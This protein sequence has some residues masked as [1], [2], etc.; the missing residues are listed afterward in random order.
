MRIQ[1]LLENGRIEVPS[2][3]VEHMQFLLEF[4]SAALQVAALVV[5]LGAVVADGVLEGFQLHRTRVTRVIE[6][7]GDDRRYGGSVDGATC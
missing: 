7:L 4:Q 2:D 3:V 5:V 6:I 1:D